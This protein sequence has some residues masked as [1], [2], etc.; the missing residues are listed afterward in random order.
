ME[1]K[2]LKGKVSLKGDVSTCAVMDWIEQENC[3]KLDAVRFVFEAPVL[4]Y[5]KPFSGELIV[6]SI[7]FGALDIEVFLEVTPLEKWNHVSENQWRIM[8]FPGMWICKVKDEFYWM[9]D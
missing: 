5:G 6:S 7:E 2:V 4:F 1:N 3:P 9:T 8:D